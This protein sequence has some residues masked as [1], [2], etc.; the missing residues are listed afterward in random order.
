MHRQ[1]SMLTD[2]VNR[3]SRAVQQKNAEEVQFC[4]RVI[5][6]IS[7]QIENEFIADAYDPLSIEI[8]GEKPKSNQFKVIDSIDFLVKPVYFK[9]ILEGN[10]IVHYS[11]ERTEELMRA[12]AFDLHNNFWTENQI[13]SGTVYGAIPADILHTAQVESLQRYGWKRNVAQLVAF[14]KGLSAHEIRQISQTY[15][16]KY[17]LFCVK[18]S[19][20]QLI[21][22]FDS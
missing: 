11:K 20:K 18:K 6:S 16:H 13:I 1:L 9:N 5:K 4:V 2:S 14:R 3:L 8:K 19:D 10:D 15:F 12:S 21:L 22:K 17:I 7:S